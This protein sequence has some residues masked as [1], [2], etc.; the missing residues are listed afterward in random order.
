MWT[1]EHRRAA[2]RNG[3]RYPSD[4]THD[5]WALVAPLI[6]PGRQGGRERSVNV[7]EVNLLPLLPTFLT[8]CF[9]RL[10]LCWS[11]SQRIQLRAFAS[12]N[13]GVVL[14]SASGGGLFWHAQF[15]PK[16]PFARS[17]CPRSSTTPSAARRIFNQE[18]G[19][20]YSDDLRIRGG[21]PT[22]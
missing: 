7:R 5:E 12:S 8:A 11:S 1:S 18:N 9:T 20:V 13:A 15:W 14:L 16:A 10:P 21:R 4:L 19:D 3:L 2:S 17:G 22:R 6:L